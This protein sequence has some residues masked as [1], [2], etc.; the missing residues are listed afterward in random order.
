MIKF[1]KSNALQT[2]KEKEDFLAKQNKLMYI[3]VNILHNDPENDKIYVSE[4]HTNDFEALKE[5]IRQIGIKQPLL[6]KVHPH[7]P[8]E[9][10]VISGHR[11]LAVAKEIGLKQVPVMVEIIE[12][13]IDLL[14]SKISLLTT[15]MLTRNRTPYEKALEIQKMK[16]LI[17]EAKKL[18]PE[19]YKGKTLDLLSECLNI[20]TRQL[21]KYT[22]FNLQ[23]NDLDEET[24]ENFKKGECTLNEVV[25]EIH[26]KSFETDINENLDIEDSSSFTFEH[27]FEHNKI[28]LKK[29]TLKEKESIQQTEN[30]QENTI[31]Q[32]THKEKSS[33]LNI[34]LEK[35]RKTL[36]F[37]VTENLE[38]TEIDQVKNLKEIIEKILSRYQ[39]E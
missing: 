30:L 26:T 2:I 25:K 32:I 19:T 10:I 39:N 8:L 33:K 18:D 34:S 4:L 17:L 24:L 21:K 5:D 27:D 13:E 38:D 20:S 23:Q 1:K 3:D 36:E 15:N 28:D 11:R 16:A 31:P 7:L 6:V 37:F 22:Q 14:R 29:D 12:N 35:V 9:Y